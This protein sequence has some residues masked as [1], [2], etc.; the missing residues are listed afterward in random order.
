[1]H[2]YVQQPMQVK[3]KKFLVQSVQ[4]CS[5]LFSRQL[6][7]KTGHHMGMRELPC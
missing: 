3:K 1:M 4:V 5:I 7:S 2:A 6:K